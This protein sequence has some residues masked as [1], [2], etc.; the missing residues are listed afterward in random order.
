MIKYLFLDDERQPEQVVWGEFDYS[1]F[2]WDIAKNYTEFII[3]LSK[4]FPANPIVISF[5]NDLGEEKEGYDCLK[6]LIEYCLDC[7]INL[8]EIFVHSQNSV[9]KENMEFLISNLKKYII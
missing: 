5:D 4:Y 7:K 9:A 6:W 3:Y 2:Q 8:P 1:D